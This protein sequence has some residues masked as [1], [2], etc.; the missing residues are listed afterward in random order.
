MTLTLTMMIHATSNNTNPFES[1]DDKQSQ[2]EHIETQTKYKFLKID[3]FEAYKQYENTSMLNTIKDFSILKDINSFFTN[4]LGHKMIANLLDMTPLQHADYLLTTKS[5]LQIRDMFFGGKIDEL[6]DKMQNVD[7]MI[8]KILPDESKNLLSMVKFI[9]LIK[10]FEPIKNIMSLLIFYNKFYCVED[11]DL[12]Y[13]QIMKIIYQIMY[14]AREQKKM[15][16]MMTEILDHII[17]MNNQGAIT[18]DKILTDFATKK[19]KNTFKQDF[20]NNITMNK[21]LSDAMNNSP[22]VIS[23]NLKAKFKL[24]PDINYTKYSGIL[25]LFHEIFSGYNKGHQS[26]VHIFASD[27][28]KHIITVVFTIIV[29]DI[30]PQQLDLIHNN[31]IEIVSIMSYLAPTMKPINVIEKI[32]SFDIFG[33]LSDVLINC[34]Y[35]DLHHLSAIADKLNT[36]MSICRSTKVNM[37]LY[38]LV[39]LG[40]D[41]LKSSGI[42]KNNQ[43]QAQNPNQ[44]DRNP[45]NDAIQQ[46][47]QPNPVGA[48]QP[49]QQQPQPNL[50]GD[51]QQAQ[52][53]PP[54]QNPANKLTVTDI[55]PKFLTQENVIKAIKE[56]DEYILTQA[57]ISEN[58]F[59]NSL[60]EAE[61][62]QIGWFKYNNKDKSNKI[63]EQHLPKIL[64][65]R[66]SKYPK[67]TQE[68]KADNDQEPN[69]SRIIHSAYHIC[70][71][72]FNIPKIAGV[73]EILDG[74]LDNDFIKEIAVGGNNTDNLS[75]LK[76]I[77]NG[78]LKEVQK[79]AAELDQKLPQK[80]TISDITK[81]PNL[82]VL[83]GQ[84]VLY[85]S[86]TTII[87]FNIE[88]LDS[89]DYN[90]TEIT[91]WIKELNDTVKDIKDENSD[92]TQPRKDDLIQ[93]IV[94]ILFIHNAEPDDPAT[95]Q[96][97][98]QNNNAADI[99]NI[100]SKVIASR[101]NF[102]VGKNQYIMDRTVIYHDAL[103]ELINKHF[104]DTVFVFDSTTVP[105]EDALNAHS[106]SLS[107]LLYGASQVLPV[108]DD[109]KELLEY[110]QKLSDKVN[111]DGL[112]ISD[113]QSLINNTHDDIKI[114]DPYCW[115]LMRHHIQC[116][117]MVN[118]KRYSKYMV[119][120]DKIQHLYFKDCSNLI[121]QYKNSGDLMTRLKESFV[122][123]A[124]NTIQDKLGANLP[125]GTLIDMK[126]NPYVKVGYG[127][128]VVSAI[129]IASIV[130]YKHMKSEDNTNT[131]YQNE[132]IINDNMRETLN[133]SA[134]S[135]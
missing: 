31:I 5:M 108:I 83:V 15:Q 128:T 66:E 87:L 130:V 109:P 59:K 30:S 115:K 11:G 106:L 41:A 43:P 112:Y 6:C 127:L 79:L 70:N 46:L 116:C 96:D 22:I 42:N 131:E 81:D 28:M 29:A 64:T 104:K 3:K 36:I 78:L 74:I 48:N 57:T 53:Q 69:K 61:W 26:I 71:I 92:I 23:D 17:S 60:S 118:E 20:Y 80:Y 91:K 98:N 1:N 101:S 125:Q 63:L 95:N 8:K 44:A 12:E 16:E 111:N 103:Q 110:I 50:V 89:D 85:G 37:P 18:F 7:M 21:K 34:E 77:L 114:Q 123:A 100:V 68:Y 67:I 47:L 122:A 40:L 117:Q 51:N 132:I 10:N 39:S 14:N 133:D 124:S 113:L 58:E 99:A 2:D 25:L 126:Y 32:L 102:E 45:V 121:E 52:Q 55:L 76:H 86:F 54:Q 56:L 24:T 65:Q 129:T 82:G 49:A 134:A 4:L 13:Q 9:K 105:D 88:E 94:S 35:N 90:S 135:A 19:K 120:E 119:T 97:K 75:S 33:I 72:V 27:F 107:Y 62:Q 73:Y 84:K 93:L 38:Q